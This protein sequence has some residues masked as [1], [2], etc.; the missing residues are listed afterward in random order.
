[1]KPSGFGD[2]QHLDGDTT[3]WAAAEAVLGGG[4]ELLSDGGGAAI[5]VHIPPDGGEPAYR[6]LIDHN[7]PG[8]EHTGS[9]AG[10][11]P[12][13]TQLLQPGIP[14]DLRLRCVAEEAGTRLTV[15]LNGLKVNEH[16]DTRGV[17]APGMLGLVPELTAGTELEV[18]A[19]SL[20]RL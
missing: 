11:A 8:Q 5:D 20:E 4:G 9:L 3:S 16:L 2:M 7:G 1:K 15:W 18:L 19:L 17:D 10:L 6:L 12:V 13:R 14:F